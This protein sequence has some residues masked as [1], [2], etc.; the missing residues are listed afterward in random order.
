MQP[1]QPWQHGTD[2]RLQ[3][4]PEPPRYR[5]ED[6]SVVDAAGHGLEQAYQ[7]PQPG[8]LDSAGGADQINATHPA[9][10]VRL[11]TS[12]PLSYHP[13][14]NQ[15]AGPSSYSRYHQS[16]HGASAFSSPYEARPSDAKSSFS[17]SANF[18][19]PHLPGTMTQP[20]I[21]MLDPRRSQMPSH[22]SAG[23]SR[24]RHHP[25]STTTRVYP[26]GTV[27]PSLKRG[28]ACGFCRKRKLRCNAERPAC[29]NCLKFKKE[30][31]YQPPPKDSD[32]EDEGEMGTCSCI[33]MGLS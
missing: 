19:P 29:S 5:P 13:Y 14:H 27:G 9:E 25:Q 31:E 28:M 26:N 10:S 12:A 24:H 23:R 20:P 15:Q 8:G 18:A 33:Y 17:G 7:A 16:Q 6:G 2:P 3:H 4:A 11:P 32:D 1:A 30:C 22:P 21:S